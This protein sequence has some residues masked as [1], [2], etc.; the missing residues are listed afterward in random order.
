MADILPD[1]PAA[2]TRMT[3]ERT[4]APPADFVANA[5]V[6]DP[7]VYET[8][9]ADPESYW[10]EWASK[11]DWFAPWHT[12]C[13]WNPPHAKWFVG[14]KINVAHNCLDRHLSTP[15]RN[16]AAILFE[17]EPGDTRVLTYHDLWRE[18][19]R[20]AGVL[21]NLGIM[22]GDRVTI[23]LPMIPEAAIAMLAC[24][25]LGAI[26]TVVFGGFSSDSLRER[27]ND[28]GSKVLITADGGYRR[29]NTVNLKGAAD[30]ALTDGACPS[31]ESVVVHNRLPDPRHVPM[32]EGR[33]HW[34]HRLV[35]TA[36]RLV[37]PEPMDSE[38][39]LFILYTSGSTGKPKGILHT[40]GGYLTG[41]LETFVSVFDHKDSDV[42]FCTADVGW[43]TGHSYVVYGPLGGR[44]RPC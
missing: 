1:S 25:R 42:Y 29:G 31:I 7:S 13:E 43:V 37:E 10:A 34:W 18:V 40:T 14:G 28:S 12:V 20:F 27:I 35:D 3:E 16:K 23:Y 39:P 11:L 15:R 22:K 44:A 8:A 24:A 19:N 9:R 33:D 38:D 41:A 26:H 2:Q 36:P 6:S 17:G 32:T 4:F 30:E 5:A 21:H